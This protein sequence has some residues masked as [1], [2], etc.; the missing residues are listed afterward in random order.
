MNRTTVAWCVLLVPLAAAGCLRPTRTYQDAPPPGVRATE[1][2][3]VDSDGFD[4]LFESALVNQDPL[5][6]VRTTHRQ[7]DWGPRL[8]AWIAAWNQGGKA[9][10]PGRVI[11]G[12]APLPAVTVNGES[13]REFRLLIDSL[14]NRAEELAGAGSTWWAVERVRSRRVALL[15][16][17]NLRFHMDDEGFLRLIFFHGKN[18][19]DYPG[20]VKTLTGADPEEPAE[21][22]RTVRCS[23]CKALRESRAV[24][25][26]LTG[27]LGGE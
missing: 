26:R 12:Q 19:G 14:V 23:V 18:A 1:I 17:Y 11:R 3:Y 20:Y 16:P 22:A 5:I 7:P 10:G 6:V 4:A 9:A 8:N 15:K 27:S 21:W 2:D 24:P 13:I 25:G